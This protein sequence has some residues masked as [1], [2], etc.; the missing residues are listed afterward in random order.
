M[1][2]ARV[3]GIPDYGHEVDSKK[4]LVLP[5]ILEFLEEID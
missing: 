5:L 2:N 4:D 1:K 3:V